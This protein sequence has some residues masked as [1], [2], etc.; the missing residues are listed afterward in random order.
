MDKG[1][2]YTAVL[3]KRRGIGTDGPNCGEQDITTFAGRFLLLVWV[4]NSFHFEVNIHAR[5]YDSSVVSTS[6]ST[7]E[8]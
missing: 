7:M 5:G 4:T 1:P 6:I 3:G 8:V 2:I